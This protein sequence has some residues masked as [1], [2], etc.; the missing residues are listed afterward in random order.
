MSA[1]PTYAS[2]GLRNATGWHEVKVISQRPGHSSVG[3][4]LDTYAHVL[5]LVDARDG[6]TLAR[7]ILGSN[8]LVV[9]LRTRTWR[10]ATTTTLVPAAGST[11]SCT[12]WPSSSSVLGVL[13]TSQQLNGR[14]DGL[15]RVRRATAHQRI[16]PIN[17]LFSP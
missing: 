15:S 13:A 17:H 1:T 9:H 14:I 5:P 3:L 10:A 6:H 12:A 16:D 4:T 2:V 7:H 11:T 8:R